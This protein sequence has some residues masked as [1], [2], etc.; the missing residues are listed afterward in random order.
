MT[1]NFKSPI[2]PQDFTS[3]LSAF[4]SQ[5]G[6]DLFVVALTGGKQGGKW[7]ELG[8]NHTIQSS[9]TWLLEKK[10]LWTGDSID[11]HDPHASNK[12]NAWTRFYFNVQSCFGSNL[13]LNYFGGPVDFE[14]LPP[15]IQKQMVEKLNYEKHVGC[16]SDNIP[17][18]D[19][20]DDWRLER[21]NAN[22]IFTDAVTLD[23]SKLTGPYDYL[24]VDIDNPFG[25]VKILEAVLPHHV[26]SVVTIEHDFKSLAPE[27]SFCRE[28][29]RKLMA[30]NGYV[31]LANDVTVEPG[32]GWHNYGKPRYFE[33]WY[34][35]PSR[36]DQEMIDLY[37]CVSDQPRPKF[38]WEILFKW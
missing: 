23:Y 11:I 38:Y 33:D 24:Q 15:D 18:L 21:P 6:Q 35:H 28:Q 34:V 13:P 5:A 17:K 4:Q 19:P 32:M 12:Q 8:A 3:L 7:L 30:D 22:L 36:I 20:V 29:S 16:K 26:F 27:N 37:T 2:P 25:H 31:L 14:V 1:V 10:F 9:N